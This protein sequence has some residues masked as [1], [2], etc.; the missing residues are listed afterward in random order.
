MKN[1]LIISIAMFGL[2]L[3]GCSNPLLEIDDTDVWHTLTGST[4]IGFW[5]FGFPDE[6]VALLVFIRTSSVRRIEYWEGGERLRSAEW[7]NITEDTIT[8]QAPNGQIFTQRFILFD[9]GLEL[10]EIPIAIAVGGVFWRRER[11]SWWSWEFDDS[12]PNLT[13]SSNN[14]IDSDGIGFWGSRGDPGNP[15]YMLVFINTPTVSRIEIWVNRRLHNWG[16]WIDAIGDTIVYRQP[17]RINPATQRYLIENNRLWLQSHFAAI[18]GGGP[19]SRFD[20][21]EWWVLEERNGVSPIRLEKDACP[22]RIIYVT[23]GL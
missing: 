1:I 21:P 18:A 12:R 22:Q 10:D 2:A 8:Y 17:D 15:D 3:A 19:W 23:G 13:G 9:N 4:G 6:P 5:G 16:H 14:F 11:P 20:R 7:L